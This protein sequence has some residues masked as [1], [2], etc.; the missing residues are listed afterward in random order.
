[1]SLWQ[2]N[3][4]CFFVFFWF[5]NYT[6]AS[7]CVYFQIQAFTEFH[8]IDMSQ[9]CSG[10]FHETESFHTTFKLKRMELMPMCCHSCC[11]VWTRNEAST[12]ISLQLNRHMHSACMQNINP[13]CN[14]LG[15]SSS[16]VMH[17]QGASFSDSCGGLLTPQSLMWLWLS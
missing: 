3:N 14:Q 15:A 4:V 12:H 7:C 6:A 5:W 13:Y 1:M 17:S 16:L 8:R 11:C 2:G 10:Q 9:Q